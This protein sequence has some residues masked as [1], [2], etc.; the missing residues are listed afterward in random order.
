[1]RPTPGPSISDSVAPPLESVECGEGASPARQA[2][3]SS[4]AAL[5]SRGDTAS[6]V[7]G[8]GGPPALVFSPRNCIWSL[9]C[10]LPSPGPSPL[11]RAAFFQL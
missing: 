1:M 4:N 6:C 9:E 2:P 7:W 8:H 3:P 11:T 5:V 10:W